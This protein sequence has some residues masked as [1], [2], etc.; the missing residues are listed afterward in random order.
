TGGGRQIE[1]LNQDIQDWHI[2]FVDTG[3]TSNIGQRIKA[4]QKQVEGDE[5][6]L[7]NYTDGLADVPL[8]DLVE[9]FKKTGKIAS[10]VSVYP[11]ATFHFIESDGDGLVS[12]IEHIRKSGARINGGFF[13]FRREI[14]DYIKDG[15]ELVEEPFRRLIDE[16]Q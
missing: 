4:V 15:E 2:T 14:F 3:L 12:S 6:F 5:I 1:L 16:R 7:A 13:I 8:N 9:K 10:F 11:K